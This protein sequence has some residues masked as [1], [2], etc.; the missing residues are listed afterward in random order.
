[1]SDVQI[2]FTFEK[3]KFTPIEGSNYFHQLDLLYK[4]SNVILE[5]YGGMFNIHND[6]H[7]KFD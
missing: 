2:D 5:L 7:I 3:I 4:V 1:M 6:G